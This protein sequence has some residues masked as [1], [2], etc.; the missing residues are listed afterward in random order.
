MNNGIKIGIGE[1]GDQATF[2]IS[3]QKGDPIPWDMPLGL[4][5]YSEGAREDFKPPVWGRDVNIEIT[6]TAAGEDPEGSFI[7]YERKEKNE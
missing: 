1:D 4:A 3:A 5:V 7:Y 6:V 2:T